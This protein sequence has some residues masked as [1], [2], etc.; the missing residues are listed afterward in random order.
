MYTLSGLPTNI[1]KRFSDGVSK[2][3]LGAHHHGANE[4]VTDDD[5]GAWLLSEG[6][7]D[8]EP[9]GGDQRRNEHREEERSQE[10]E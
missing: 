3:K 10:R 8:R 1:L 7:R 9:E 2:G 4:G 5:E 6:R